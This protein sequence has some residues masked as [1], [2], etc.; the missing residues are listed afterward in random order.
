MLQH[1]NGPSVHGSLFS[2][3]LVQRIEKPE[4]EMMYDNWQGA[5]RLKT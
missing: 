2:G 4:H 1:A 5:A 3:D